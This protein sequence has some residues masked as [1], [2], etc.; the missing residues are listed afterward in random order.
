MSSVTLPAYAKLNL[1]LDVLARRS[2]GYHEL[3]TLFERID[4]YDRVTVELIDED[5]VSL[6]CDHPEV[7]LDGQNLAFKAALLYRKAAGFKEGIRIVLEK[8]IPVAGGLGGGSSDAATV[9]LALQQLTGNL[10]P[11]LK[12]LELAKGLGADVPF[13]LAQLPWALGRGRGDEIEPLGITTRVWHL[14]VSPGF[15]IPTKVVYEAFR[16]PTGQAGLTGARPDVTLLT[17]ALR[18]NHVA[19]LRDLVFNALEPTVEALYPKIRFVKSVLKEHCGLKAVLV[20]GS[21]STVM[22]LC[23]TADEAER[24]KQTLEAQGS[25]WQIFVAATQ[26]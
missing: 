6:S 25:S 14:L 2:D 13:F 20:S 5:R 22:G 3:V 10:V 23:P 19:R 21:G 8:K 1:Y 4:L 12:L 17:R 16:H 24:I 11:N 18:D 15:P 9:L 7:P 26:V